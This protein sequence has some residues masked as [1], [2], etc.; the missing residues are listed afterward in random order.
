[1]ILSYNNQPDFSRLELKAEQGSEKEISKNLIDFAKLVW[2]RLAEIVEK[3]GLC[4]QVPKVCLGFSNKYYILFTWL[5]DNH[6]LE[7]EIFGNKRGIEFFYSYRV[8]WGE[9]WADEESPD[10]KDLYL[11][12]ELLEKFKI[13]AR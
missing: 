5:K 2:E 9:I 11:N 13:F 6:Y 12:D 4:L 7:C 3:Q 8:P 1:M 10:L